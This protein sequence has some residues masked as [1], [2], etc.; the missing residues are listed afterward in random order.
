MLSDDESDFTR[1]SFQDGGALV[2]AVDVYG[3]RIDIDDDVIDI[4]YANKRV[5]VPAPKRSRAGT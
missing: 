1:V 2:G 4:R 5:R 3:D